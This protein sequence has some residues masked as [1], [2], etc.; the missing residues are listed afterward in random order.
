MAMRNVIVLG[1]IV[2]WLLLA[3]LPAAN[4][5]F[6]DVDADRVQI[7]WALGKFDHTVYFAEIAGREDR[8]ASFVALIEI[9]GIDHHPVECRVSDSRSHRLMRKALMKNW[10]ESEFEIVNTTFMSDL[11]Y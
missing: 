11:D 9:S 6:A 5:A 8:Q 4:P 3:V 10:S 7:C 2:Q 1:S